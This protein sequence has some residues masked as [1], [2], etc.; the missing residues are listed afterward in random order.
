MKEGSEI[1]T[2]INIVEYKSYS[3]LYIKF[4]YR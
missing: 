1:D 4:K 3:S 2:E